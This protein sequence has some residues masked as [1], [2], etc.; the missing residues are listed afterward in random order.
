MR[1]IPFS[2]LM[3]MEEFDEFFKQP[4]I[5]GFKP[6]IDVYQENDNVIAEA[7]ISNLDPEKVNVSIENDILT[8]SGQSEKKSEID[9]KKYYRKEV[10]YGSFQRQIALPVAV[11]GDK[12]EAEYHD[13]ILKITIPKASQAKK[14]T[15]KIK[16]TK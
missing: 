16:T 12:A 9:D 14:K 4:T 13:G 7:P 2:P 6:A 5:N 3:E 8:I 1:L 11:D 15:I 10:R